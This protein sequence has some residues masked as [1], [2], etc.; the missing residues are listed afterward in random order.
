MKPRFSCADFTFPLL[1]HDKV[2][3]LLNLLGFEAVD[4]GVFE[5]RSH[6]SPSQVNEDPRGLAKTIKANLD[7]NH[8][9]V[10]DVFLQTGE[11]PSISA[12]NDPDSTARERNRQWF[13]AMLTFTEELNCRHLTGLPGVNHT[14][15]PL[16]TD[17]NLAVGEAHWRVQRAKQAGI[18]YSIEAHVGSILPDPESTLRFLQEVP[19]L[20]LTLDY[21]H[22]IYQGMSNESAHPLLKYASHFH[23]RGGAKGQLQSTVKEN[24][25]DFKAVVEGMAKCDYQGFLCLEYVWVDWEGCNRT[26]NIAETLLLRQQIESYANNLRES[27]LQRDR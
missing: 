26:D 4:L 23:A 3:V 22:F 17:W 9:T 19:D 14:S 16:N 13:E 24:T 20:T 7:A 1:S 11:E 18:A 25:I 10:S 21:G 12:A 6:Y 15:I 27:G 5:G 8:L 2:L